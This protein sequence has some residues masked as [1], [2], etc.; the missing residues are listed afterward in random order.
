MQDC[1][2][3]AA[4][5]DVEAARPAAPRCIGARPCGLSTLRAALARGAPVTRAR[6]RSTGSSAMEQLADYSASTCTACCPLG[7]LW[8]CAEAAAAQRSD[9]LR[10]GPG[11]RGAARAG[12]PA[13]RGRC[14]CTGRAC[15][16]ILKAGSPGAVT[17][18]AGAGRPHHGQFRDGPG[19]GRSRLVARAGPPGPD[20]DA[21]RAAAAAVGLAAHGL[22]RT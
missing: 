11:V 4:A 14:R 18:R 13:E 12:R 8:I 20:P 15:A 9:P 7:R 3:G 22:T 1:Q 19:D 16:A 2:L 21:S 17:P 5:L 6:C 10:S